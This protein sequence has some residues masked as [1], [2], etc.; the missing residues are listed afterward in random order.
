MDD[1]QL[2]T[3]AKNGDTNAFEQLLMK[4]REQLYRTAFL[5]VGNR[6]DA[7]DVVQETAYRSFESIGKLKNDSFFLTWV[8]RILI[9]CS[10]A[11][12][13]KRQIQEPIEEVELYINDNTNEKI[14][15]KEAIEQLQEKYQ[16]AII[17]FYYH[18]YSIKHIAETMQI[19][20]N[21]VKTYLN[22]G[23][24]ELRK[25]IEGGSKNGQTN[26]S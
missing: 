20:E 14:E 22:R 11:I 21:T 17:L 19:P 25:L 24:K 18:D 9:N 10:N 12:I 5:Y 4:H 6:A 13:K 26:I 15:M 8:T 7:L 1:T 23:R 16:T 2:V 3:L